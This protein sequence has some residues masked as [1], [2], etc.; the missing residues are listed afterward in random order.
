MS[1]INAPSRARTCHT[2]M[3]HV[4]Y[5]VTYKCVMLNMNES[6]H[7]RIIDVTYACAK[8]NMNMI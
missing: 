6:C 5:D 8:S 2:G 3:S 7:V 4:T 1:R